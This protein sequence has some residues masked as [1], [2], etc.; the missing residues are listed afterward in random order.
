[1]IQVI[2][3]TLSNDLLLIL[4]KTKSFL[5]WFSDGSETLIVVIVRKVDGHINIRIE[6]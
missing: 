2:T 6:V 5:C 1:M 4:S 3:K